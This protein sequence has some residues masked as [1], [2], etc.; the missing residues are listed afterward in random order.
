MSLIDIEIK[1]EPDWG[2]EERVEHLLR[3]VLANQ[4]TLQPKRRTRRKLCDTPSRSK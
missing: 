4:T 2:F 3:L 1:F